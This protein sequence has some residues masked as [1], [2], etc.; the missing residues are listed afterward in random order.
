M[1]SVATIQKDDGWDDA[2][3][4]NAER[5]IKGTLLK[6]SEWRWTKGKEGTH[7]ACRSQHCSRLGEM[8]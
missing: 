4:E 2:A 7:P 6:F 5:V 8:V 3:A 1:N